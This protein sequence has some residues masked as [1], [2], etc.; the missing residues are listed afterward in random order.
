MPQPKNIEIDLDRAK[1]E[2]CKRHLWYFAKEFWSVIIPNDLKWNWHM[3][4]LCDEAQIVVQRALLMQNKEY[5]LITNV[6]PGTSKTTLFSIMCT[7]WEF[8]NKPSVKSAVGSY[9]DSAVLSIADK[10]RIVVQSEKYKRY[11]P[12]VQIR[13]G[14]NNMHEF[15]TTQNGE[16]FAFTVCG[17]LTSKHYDILKVDDPLNPKMAASEAGIIAANKFF[18]ETLPTRK[19][20]KKVTPTMLIMQRLHHNDPTGYILEKKKDKIRHVCLPAEL[21]TITTNEYREFYTNGL[22]DEVRLDREVLTEMRIDLGSN[23]YAKQFEQSPTEDGGNIIKKDW[24]R[25]ISRTDF[26]RMRRGESIEYFVDTAF[27]DKSREGDPTGIIAT[28]KIR[29]DLYITKAQKVYLQFPELIK[30][31]PTFARNNSYDKMGAIR[32]E[33]KSNGL[34]VIQT[35]SAETKLNVTRTVTPKDSKETRLNAESPKIE[36][37][38]VYLIED[39]WND[40]FMDEIAGFPFKEHDEY[41][42]LIAYAC[43][44]HLPNF[45]QTAQQ[46]AN[47]F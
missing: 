33:P 3:K 2:M 42:D 14:K 4:V 5:D 37:G 8:A 22:L 31:I 19:V 28:C 38:R 41:V 29:N 17:T 1:A 35:L 20:D 30:F 26:E 15:K 32:I 11:F 44:F 23:G 47:Y 24:F 21:S 6:P 25:F 9:S 7:A 16:F 18:S 46:L 13:K 39:H 45:S 40:D 43:N 34:S 12:E 36:C 10:I 27:G